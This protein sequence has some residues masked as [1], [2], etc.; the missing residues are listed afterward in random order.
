MSRACRHA[1]SQAAIRRPPPGRPQ[2]AD[3]G[4]VPPANVP[5]SLLAPAPVLHPPGFL[6]QDLT[7]EFNP[8]RTPAPTIRETSGF[9]RGEAASNKSIP[10]S[11]SA[12]SLRAPAE[13][14]ATF[15]Q[16][17]LCALSQGAAAHNPSSERRMAIIGLVLLL[18]ACS[19]LGAAPAGGASRL[20]GR[21]EDR[22]SSS[23]LGSVSRFPERSPRPSLRPRAAVPT[24]LSP[25]VDLS[26]SG[27]CG[28]WWRAGRGRWP[29]LFWR[30]A[31]LQTHNSCAQAARL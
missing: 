26:A 10:H 15:V 17:A 28:E 22:E 14:P 5:P 6:D 8:A 3:V 12:R 20:P 27:P 2:D 11:A 7:L 1:V 4:E 24:C 19:T 29:T 31:S 21:H 13:V 9:H 18:L 16:R 23:R 25:N 30:A